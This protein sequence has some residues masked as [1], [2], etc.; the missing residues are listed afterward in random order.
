MSVTFVK[1]F[2]LVIASMPRVTHLAVD[3]LHPYLTSSIRLGLVIGGTA[4]LLPALTLALRRL[5]DVVGT[6][7][8]NNP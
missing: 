6:P 5:N 3:V 1:P 7:V 2:C 4:V 8:S